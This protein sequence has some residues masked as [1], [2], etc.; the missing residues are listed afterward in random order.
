MGTNAYNT[1]SSIELAGDKIYITGAF[2]GS[3]ENKT[4]TRNS[5][6]AFIALY[7]KETGAQNWLEKAGHNHEDNL[8]IKRFPDGKILVSGFFSNTFKLKGEDDFEVVAIN[9]KNYKDLFVA[10]LIDCS[11]MPAPDIG[12]DETACASY[13]IKAPD[14]YISYSW[15]GGAFSDVKTYTATETRTVRLTVI[16][17]NNCELSSEVAITINEG[18]TIDLGGSAKTICEGENLVLD[19]G[20]DYDNY[21]WDDESTLQTRT[22]NAAGTYTVQAN[23]ATTCGAG[24]IEVTVTPA[25]VVDLGPDVTAPADTTI[26]IHTNLSYDEYSFKWLDNS[27]QRHLCVPMSKVQQLG[28]SV[29]LWVEVTSL[30]TGCT[31]RASVMVRVGNPP[32]APLAANTDKNQINTTTD[33][34]TTNELK[35]Y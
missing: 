10:K 35:K 14:G 5:K 11:T 2:R 25:P 27:T 13:Q 15:N 28:G 31:T 1:I 30:A 26:Y 22:V 6:D 3:L 19:A 29:N 12:E 7:Q 17:N 9:D 20:S 4:S 23:N 24:S 16:D 21:F 8:K 33:N 18:V 34:E 32:T